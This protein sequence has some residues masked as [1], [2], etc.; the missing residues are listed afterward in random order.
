MEYISNDPKNKER[1]A[2]WKP[3]DPMIN[4][5]DF[6]QDENYKPADPEKAKMS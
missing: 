3:G 5:H 1:M 2:K 6:W 4:E